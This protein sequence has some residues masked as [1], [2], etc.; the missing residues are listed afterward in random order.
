MATA[1]AAPAARVAAGVLLFR[2]LT[3]ALPIPLGALS[4]LGW[5]LNRSWR[6]T[7]AEREDRVG[8]L[9]HVRA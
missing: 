9:E 6:M 4:L 5:R 1:P 3:H 7:P 2:A 8:G